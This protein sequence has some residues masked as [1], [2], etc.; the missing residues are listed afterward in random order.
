MASNSDNF[1]GFADTSLAL[2]YPENP[3]HLTLFTLSL[4]CMVTHSL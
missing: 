1:G 2:N 4:P 3:H